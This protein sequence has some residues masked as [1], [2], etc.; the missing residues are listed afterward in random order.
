[1]IVRVT[2]QQSFAGWSL[3]EEQIHK[4]KT[5]ER[6][7]GGKELLQWGEDLAGEAERFWNDVNILKQA[8]L[9]EKFNKKERRN[10]QI[11]TL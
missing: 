1:M 10:E 7:E 2:N 6:I 9:L 4:D 3:P 11:Y 5:K 8:E